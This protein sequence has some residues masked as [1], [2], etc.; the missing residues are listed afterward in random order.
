MT[1]C[2]L[3]SFSEEPCDGRL[4]RAHLIPRQR[5]VREVTKTLPKDEAFEVIW[6]ERVWVPVC[7]GV[8]GNAGHHGMFDGKSLRVPRWALPEGVEEYAAQYGLGWSLDREYGP[9][10]LVA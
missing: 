5:I 6:D 10:E 2:W 4:I 3:A 1:C 9:R 7:G 8:M